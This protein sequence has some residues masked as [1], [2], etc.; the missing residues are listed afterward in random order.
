[1]SVAPEKL[2]PQLDRIVVQLN[3]NAAIHK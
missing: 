3:K 2:K 1:M